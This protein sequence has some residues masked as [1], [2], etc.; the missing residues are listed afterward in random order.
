MKFIQNVMHVVFVFMSGCGY[1]RLGIKGD[2]DVCGMVAEGNRMRVLRRYRRG[3][4]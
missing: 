4:K 1:V 2:S 3:Y